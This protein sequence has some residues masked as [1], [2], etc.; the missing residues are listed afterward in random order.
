MRTLEEIIKEYAI[1]L[2]FT[3]WVELLDNVNSW[4]LESIMDEVWTEYNLTIYYEN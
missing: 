3:F 4:E 1:E 2:G